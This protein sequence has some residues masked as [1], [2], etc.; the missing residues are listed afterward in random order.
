MT[1]EIQAPHFKDLLAFDILPFVEKPEL[2][3]GKEG[4]TV[5]K[6]QFDIRFCLIFADG[7]MVSYRF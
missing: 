3:V 1:A 4:G 7:C 2:Y 6:K 5:K